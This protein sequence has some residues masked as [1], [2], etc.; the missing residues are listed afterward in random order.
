MSHI[1]EWKRTLPLIIIFASLNVVCDSVVGL[2]Q[3]SSGVWYSWI[4]IVAPITGIILG[5]YAGFLSTLIGVMIGHFIYFRGI[6]EFLFTIGAPIGATISGLMFRGKWKPV[7]AYY[8]VLLVTYFITPIAWQLPIW[9]MWNTYFAY[10]CVAILIT[11]GKDAWKLESNKL[12]YALALSAFIGLEADILFRIFI[13][14]PCQTYQL[15]YGFTIEA[16]QY[17]WYTAALTTPIQVA[18][19]AL[20]TAIV[21][22][23][24]IRVLKN[25]AFAREPKKSS[26][27]AKVQT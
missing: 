25:M 17:I 8:T 5:T 13:F 21:G 27:E 24:L 4:F 2:P 18:M 10:L 15:F 6:H 7:F 26:Q 11:V 9:G 12:P 14:I 19:S 16:L 22:P 20:A 1:T 3:F 23:P